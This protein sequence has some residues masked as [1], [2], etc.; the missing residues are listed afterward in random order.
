MI[1]KRP[2]S[3][4]V[5]GE[6]MHI[7]NV[8]RKD[9]LGG[10]K[11]FGPLWNIQTAVATRGVRLKMLSL[12]AKT[13]QHRPYLIYLCF[14][15][16]DFCWNENSFSAGGMFA[17][18]TVCINIYLNFLRFQQA[19]EQKRCS[20]CLFPT[21]F[22]FLNSKSAFESRE[23]L[24]GGAEAWKRPRVECSRVKLHFRQVLKAAPIPA[25]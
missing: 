10:C 6:S 13:F 4:C 2:T 25:L 16:F 24:F 7:S 12:P 5:P 23:I 15:P 20:S 22:A 18:P 1:R 8:S 9:E 11:L 17:H 21:L 14:F 19:S 3:F